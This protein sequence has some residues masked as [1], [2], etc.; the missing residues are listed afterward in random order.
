MY[1]EKKSLIKT[2]YM[3]TIYDGHSHI[4]RRVYQDSKGRRFVQINGW[5][6]NVLDLMA[7]NHFD[8]DVW[9]EG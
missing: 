4:E 5:M 8:L 6:A 7:I 1:I 3:A 2:K 9:Y